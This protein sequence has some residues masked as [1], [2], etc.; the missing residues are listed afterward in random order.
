MHPHGHHGREVE[1]ADAGDDADRLT[2]GVDVHAGGD[3]EGV[4]ALEGQVDGGGEVEGLAPALDLADG[5][6]VVLAVLGHDH[7]GHL[8]LVV[9]DQL[10]HAEHDG[11]ALGQRDLRP[12]LLGSAGHLDGVVEVGVG[13]LE[14]LGLDLTGSRVLDGEAAIG[15]PS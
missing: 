13:G 7:L 15:F 5:V 12:L 8:V 4:L 1:G 2:Q 6:G 10:A 14:Q 3:V 11:G 9:Q